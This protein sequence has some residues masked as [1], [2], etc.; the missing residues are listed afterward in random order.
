MRPA[1][2]PV[3]RP[4]FMLDATPFHEGV[5]RCGRREV[6]W[7]PGLPSAPSRRVSVADDVRISRGAC[8]GAYVVRRA[9][10]VTVAGP[11][12]GPPR[13][14]LPPPLNRGRALRNEVG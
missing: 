6:S 10:P 3:H 11:G 9:S 5:R 8:L 13:L 1:I 14:P 7:L 12:P 4:S 2:R